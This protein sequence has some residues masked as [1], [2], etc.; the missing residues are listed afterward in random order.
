MRQYGRN[1]LLTTET[2][3]FNVDLLG[4]ASP[5]A[6]TLFKP[7][8]KRI[9]VHSVDIKHRRVGRILRFPWIR[10]PRTVLCEEWIPLLLDQK[11]CHDGHQAL[12]LAMF[13]SAKT[14]AQARHIGAYSIAYD[15]DIKQT[16]HLHHLCCHL[17]HPHLWR[18]LE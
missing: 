14:R 18:N 13:P 8:A 16:V 9:A 6:S 4:T 1:L 7:W 10:L 15:I 3:Q 12:L 17:Y 2:Q 11:I 5:I